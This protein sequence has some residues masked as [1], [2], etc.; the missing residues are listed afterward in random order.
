MK[1]L[2]PLLFLFLGLTSNNIH[3]QWMQQ[4]P[5]L[6]GA[7]GFG[8]LYQGQ[9]SALSADGNTVALSYAQD[10]NRIEGGIYIF[11]KAG[12]Q[13]VQQNRL[14]VSWY[15][16]EASISADMVLSKDGNTLAISGISGDSVAVYTYNG[17]SWVQQAE[18]QVTSLSTQSLLQQLAMAY[19][20]N[21]LVYGNGVYVRNGFTWGL[22]AT[23]QPNDRPVSIPATCDSDNRF[24]CTATSSISAD[25]NT[26]VIGDFYDADSSHNAWV[27]VRNGT[28]WTQQGPR[29]EGYG[30]TGLNSVFGPAA[31][32]VSGDGNTIAIGSNGVTDAD[33]VWVFRRVNNI[34][35]SGNNGSLLHNTDPYNRTGSTYLSINY[36]GNRIVKVSTTFL[37]FAAWTFNGTTWV[38][39]DTLYQG[40]GINLNHFPTAVS[41]SN[42]TA[43]SAGD[44][45]LAWGSFKNNLGGG[46]YFKRSANTYVQVGGTIF[47]TGSVGASGYNS[48]LKMSADAST[49]AV[50][51]L[52]DNGME[53]AVWVYNR[54][55]AL[56][57]LVG[58]KLSVADNAWQRRD[59]GNSVALSANGGVLAVGSPASGF[60]SSSY[61]TYAGCNGNVYI[62]RRS[63]QAYN[64]T[65]SLTGDVVLS[66]MGSSVS[67]SNDGNT[68]LAGGVDSGAYV[69]Y[70]TGSAW[71]KQGYLDIN[72]TYCGPAVL[73]GDGNTAVIGAPNDDNNK[74]DIYIFTRS[75]NTWS[76]QAGP[77]R[78]ASLY[79]GYNFPAS[80]SISENGNFIAAGRTAG[81][82]VGAVYLYTRTGNTW[83]DADSLSSSGYAVNGNGRGVFI[84]TTGDTVVETVSSANSPHLDVFVY[85][86]S[87]GQWV[88]TPSVINVNNENF[89]SFTE[90]VTASADAKFIACN[91]VYPPT[92]T[93]RVFRL[94]SMV[95]SLV[96]NVSATCL[97]TANG[98]LTVQARGGTPPYKFTWSNNAPNS[99][100]AANLLPGTY[101]VTIND[102]GGDTVVRQY[103]VAA[104][105]YLVNANYT[106][107]WNCTTNSG[108]I[109]LSITGGTGPYTYTWGTTPA[110][111]TNTATGLSGGSYGYTVADANG[112]LYYDSAQLNPSTAWVG[113]TAVDDDICA[114]SGSATI[115]MYGGA[116]P[117]SYS[118]STGQTTANI[119]SLGGGTY[120]A[121]VTDATGCSA[122]GAA[123][124][125]SYCNNLI[126]GHIFFDRNNNCLQDGLEQNVS[127][128]T[129]IADNGT[130][131][132]YGNTDTAGNYYIFTP[133]PGTFTVSI[134]HWQQCSYPVCTGS[135]YPL[136]AVV[137]GTL[138]TVHLADI[139]LVNPGIDLAVQAYANAPYPGSAFSY[140]TYYG[141]LQDSVIP[142]G[143]LTITYDSL[144]VFNGTTPPYT[145]LDTLNHTITF[146]LTNIG[147]LYPLSTSVTANFTLPNTVLPRTVLLMQSSIIPVTT[148]CNPLNNTVLVPVYVAGSLD[149]NYKIAYPENTLPSGDSVLTYTIHFQNIG[150]DSTHFIQVLDTL[151]ANLNPASVVTIATSNPHYTFTISKGG[152]LSWTFNPLFLPDSTTNPAG[153]QGFVTFKV[154]TKGLL[155]AGTSIQNS[156]SV[157]FDYNTPVIT[158]RTNNVVSAFGVGRAA[159][160]KNEFNLQLFP[161]PANNLVNVVTE[162]QALGGNLQIT[163]VTGRVLG[164]LAITAI[165]LP[166]NTATLATGAYFLKVNTIAGLHAVGKLMIAR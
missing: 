117:Y 140:T 131:T 31:I 65:D 79:Q 89:Y 133:G 119:T 35:Q 115:T 57:N 23:L 120:N 1:R 82:Y 48:A 55:G 152:I 161:N 43:D 144:L 141:N 61:Y 58:G 37:S 125:N 13:W 84:T 102:A 56:W 150:N 24:T 21:T 90:P 162:T 113:T 44:V 80:L 18:W 59:F 148:D 16:G 108:T 147:L 104:L 166:V 15:P 62:Y 143:T 111:H 36:D 19:D 6:T 151:S 45:L 142:T 124:V 96:S 98:S 94:M 77:L 156:A 66:G 26:I 105:R 160:T 72:A 99:P 129:M 87:G 53:G 81:E 97:Q 85:A 149:P 2:I 7:G 103:T 159:V 93:T 29:L 39:N 126:Q 17:F 64:L 78:P 42:I 130:Y 91:Y 110:Q 127:G 60:R 153:S 51:V 27:F 38:N 71:L 138:D 86:K 157:Y 155:Q 3:A 50:G 30:N 41:F 5:A 146:N 49:L 54:Q 109:A 68:L 12:G 136:T 4:C 28:N 107:S 10:S 106:R 14:Q 112:C 137:T 69:Y 154:N 101:T 74:G 11:R 165:T 32:V 40:A 121:T 88:L 70:W 116:G 8:N 123:V 20:G 145:T 9:A 139:A 67:L 63:G 25:G 95:D 132:V 73:S 34:W 164:T 75:G 22:Q 114:H 128:L 122:T 52:D 76:L 134:A 83:S 92:A 158:N 47:G 118:W 100:T 46:W 163:D 135:T 33:S